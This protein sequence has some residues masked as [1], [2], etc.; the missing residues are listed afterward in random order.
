MEVIQV[1]IKMVGVLH[2]T[3]VKAVEPLKILSRVINLKL[4]SS[5]KH[6]PLKVSRLLAIFA[7]VI[8]GEYALKILILLRE[9]YG[10]AS[11]LTLITGSYLIIMI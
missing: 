7:K 1:L 9:S 11:L 10:G 8:A 5:L 2:F 3:K 4:Q 6:T